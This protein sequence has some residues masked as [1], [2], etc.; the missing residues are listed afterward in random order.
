MMKL[1]N[2]LTVELFI[3][4]EVNNF[5]IH[6]KVNYLINSRV[7]YFII[8]DDCLIDNSNYLISYC[9]VYSIYYY[10]SVIIS[11]ASR[12]I[13]YVGNDWSI[14]WFYITF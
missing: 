13:K 8:H 4:S 2:A 6:D 3:N 10:F 9:K 5:I 11:I 7:N 1:I 14:N 12:W